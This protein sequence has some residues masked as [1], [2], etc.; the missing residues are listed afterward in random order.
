MRGERRR[1]RNSASGGS[2]IRSTLMEMNKLHLLTF[3]AIGLFLA[4]CA[5]KP[6]VPAATETPQAAAET[7][8]A[9]A[10]PTHA[11]AGEIQEVDPQ[12]GSV[13]VRTS[14]GEVHRVDVA[15]HTQVTGLKKESSE[16]GT[17]VAGMAKAVGSDIKRGSMVVVRYTEKEGKL[18]A[19]EVKHD[20]KLVVKQSEVVIHK[21]ADGGKK[22]LVKTKDG[23]EHA[24]E[25]GKD[26]TVTAGKK[27]VAV[28]SVAGSKISEGASATL[29]FTEETGNKIVHF[30][31]QQ[32]S[33]D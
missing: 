29:H 3:T 10:E 22:V 1:L 9:P 15:P 6:S 33:T 28:G 23:A 27:I 19:H 8:A 21:V 4:G 5:S 32:G 16:T 7:P 12:G 14:N 24:Y 25:V 13:T 20:S 18:V 17:G 11:I 30:A 26:A 31:S 2:G